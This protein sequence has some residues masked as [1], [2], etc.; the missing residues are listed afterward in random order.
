DWAKSVALNATATATLIPMV[1]P[2]WLAAPAGQALFFDDPRGGAKFF[3]GHRPTKAAQIAL[4]R[5]WA[6]DTATTGPK[7]HALTPNPVPPATRARFSPGEARA[8]LAHPDT[9]ALRLLAQIT[10]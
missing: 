5:S 8:P 6:A 10:L 7:V 3:A 4:A 2:L 9:E 1:S